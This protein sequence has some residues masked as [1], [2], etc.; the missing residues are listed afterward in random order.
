MTDL[1]YIMP[2][3]HP[4]AVEVSKLNPDPENARLHDERNSKVVEESLTTFKQRMPI[5]V[6][7]QGMIV[8]AG[9]A[10]LLAAQRL[11]WSHIAAVV[12]DESD[13]EATAFAIADNRSSELGE[14]D[15]AQLAANLENVDWTL[16][17]FD[18]DTIGF[19]E[20]EIE[21]FAIGSA[22]DDEMANREHLEGTRENIDGSS[23]VLK[24]TQAEANRLASMLALEVVTSET[25]LSAIERLIESNAA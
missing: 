6:Q 2:S 15:F 13:V 17:D 4:L 18:L 9:N 19:S 22:W 25:L 16:L 14:W 20:K 10:R 3:L 1:H 24:F 21:G 23:L 8:R 7:K 12:V 5:V 11:G